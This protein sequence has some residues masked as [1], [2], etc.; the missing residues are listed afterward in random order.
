MFEI[1]REYHR[2]SE[3]HDLYKGQAQGGISTPKSVP[4]VFIFTSD[5]GEQYGYSD[6]YHDDGLF[7][8]TG[9]GQSGDMKMDKGNRAILE[10]AKDGKTIYVF[11][12]TRKAH[13]SF[14]GIAVCVGYHEETRHDKDGQSRNVFVFHLDLDSSPEELTTDVIPPTDDK[15]IAKSLKEKSLEELRRAAMEKAPAKSSPSV[16]E[17]VSYYRSRALKAYV[18]QRAKGVCEGCDEPAP[19]ETR[20]GAYL[21]VHHIHRVSDGGP[22]HPENV[23]GVCPNC[24]RRAHYSKDKKA[25][26]ETLKGRVLQIEGILDRASAA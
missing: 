10:H 19:F 7:Y 16:R 13:V 12:Y 15:E 21:E 25:F 1:G 24:H 2:K 26:N 14:M 18:M 8:Y 11:E 20:K 6:G 17:H 3:I 22:D 5:A 9:E 23:V 4:A